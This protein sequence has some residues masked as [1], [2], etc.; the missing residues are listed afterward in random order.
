MQIGISAN[1]PPAILDK[2]RV[3]PRTI[4]TSPYRVLRVPVLRNSHISNTQESVESCQVGASAPH[5][6]GLRVKGS[7]GRGSQ[8]TTVRSRFKLD[9]G[10]V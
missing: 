10:K 1:Q 6:S 7:G 8:L 5:G 3:I 9:L 4:S 2:G